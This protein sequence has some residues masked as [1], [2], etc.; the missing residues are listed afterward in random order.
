MLGESQVQEES[1]AP[2]QS[3]I[4][5]QLEKTDRPR[6]TMSTPP[7]LQTPLNEEKSLK[8]NKEGVTPSERT[9]SQAYA[10]T[11]QEKRQR[12]NHV[13]EQQY[14][15][16]TTNATTTEREGSRHATP[17]GAIIEPS[18]SHTQILER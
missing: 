12:I 7:V 8:R 9:T 1:K 5:E 18:T 14:T 16:E 13:S 11:N 6:A 15:K 10:E 2:D 17:S 3:D 4:P